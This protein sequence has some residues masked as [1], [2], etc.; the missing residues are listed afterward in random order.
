MLYEMIA[1]VPPFDSEEAVL[2]MG[3]HISASVP[4]FEVRAPDVDVPEAVGEPKD[5]GRPTQCKIHYSFAPSMS[6][7]IMYMATPQLTMFPRPALRGSARFTA[8][9][10]QGYFSGQKSRSRMG[11]SRWRS[12]SQTALS[13]TS[14][15]RY[16]S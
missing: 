9:R 2:L 16:R 15:S 14:G 13:A 5:S 11:M 6:D 1:G 10:I 8:M 3:Q 7:G 12:G 4:P